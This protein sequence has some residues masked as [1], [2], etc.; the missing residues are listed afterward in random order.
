M[1]LSNKQRLNNTNQHPIH[2]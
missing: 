1:S 2:L